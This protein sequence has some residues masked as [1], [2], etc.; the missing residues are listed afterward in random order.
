MTSRT[1]PA[2]QPDGQDERPGAA[3]PHSP[4]ALNSAQWRY[5]LARS[6]KEFRRDRCLD[7]STALAF[8]SALVTFPTML[9]L[10]SLLGM[11]G[12]TSRVMRFT[13]D[14]IASLGS[15]ETAKSV[16]ALFAAL[17]EAPAGYAFVLGLFLLMWSA[18]G[19]VTAFGRAM[20][21]IYGV[22]EGRTAWKLRV[23][24]VPL[25]ALLVFLLLLAAGAM[26]LGGEMLGGLDLSD[27]AVLAWNIVRVPLAFALAA[28]VIALLYYFSP[29]VKH[30]RLRWM[31]VGAAGA[32]TVW[33]LAS[34][35]LTLYFANF[36]SFDRSYGAIGGALVFLLWLW[37]SN[38]ALLL[39]GEF[40]AELERMRQLRS[41]RAAE[42]HI[43]IQ[44]RDTSAVSTAQNAELHDVIQARTI[45]E[46][47]R[48]ARDTHAD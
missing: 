14:T 7:Q 27:A 17:A 9:V 2:Q 36:S 33:V 45:K 35:G 38:V 39:G 47:A 28:T 5:V 43:F 41:G 24:A 25:G 48:R 20:N 34:L 44:L 19:Y 1:H 16:R 26:L 32:L 6:V 13:V 21:S 23:A 22:A 8:R 46:E 11:L 18:S 15:D 4:A 31:S 37:L 10:V 29:N 42:A 3:A 40:D 30:P 12:E